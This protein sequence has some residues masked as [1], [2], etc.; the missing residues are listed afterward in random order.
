MP[1]SKKS[2]ARTLP[3]L[4]ARTA[5]WRL[6][7]EKT[8]KQFEKMGFETS[9]VESIEDA[10]TMLLQTIVPA[11]SPKTVSFGGSVSVQQSGVLDALLAQKDIEVLNTYEYSLP[12]EAMLELRRK[13]LTV[14]LF[15]TSVNAVA[16]TGQLVLLDGIGNRTAAVQFGPKKVVLLIGRN[17]LCPTLEAAMHR[18]R[19][20]AGPAN[21]TRLNR[22]TPCTKTGE[23]M[24]CQSP[25]RICSTWTITERSFPKGRIHLLFINEEVGF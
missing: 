13:A 23:C 3:V 25:D 24:N 6:H 2:C 17:K 15:I 4:E 22:Q 21:A 10:A 9:L 18:T 7:L 14:D 19:N 12:A 5:T 1:T 11:C 16:E 20:I 8:A